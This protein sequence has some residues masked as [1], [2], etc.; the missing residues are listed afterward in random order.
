[1]NAYNYDNTKHITYTPTQR[2]R[3]W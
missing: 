2:F 1:V 3:I